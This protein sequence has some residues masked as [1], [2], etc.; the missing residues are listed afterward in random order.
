M[1]TLLPSLWENPLPKRFVDNLFND[2][3]KF[4]KFIDNFF[5]ESFRGFYDHTKSFIG[6]KDNLK[7]DQ[8]ILEVDVPG[9]ERDDINVS[10]EDRRLLIKG[11]SKD[12]SRIIEKS[13]TLPLNVNISD[14][15]P[16]AEL[17]N[18]ILK[19]VFN[20]DVEKNETKQI[21]IK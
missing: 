9:F 10:Y 4:D 2:V 17:E 15:I 14:D 5:E 19:L 11:K 18:G 20:I 1:N 21:K 12:E 8:Y 13:F 3:T 6:V 16:E 7:D